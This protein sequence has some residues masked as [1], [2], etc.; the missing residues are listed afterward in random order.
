MLY[1]IIFRNEIGSEEII[2]IIIAVVAILFIV[3]GILVWLFI[4]RKS[5]TGYACKYFTCIFCIIVIF[6]LPIG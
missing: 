1:F 2:G 4:F 6:N 5:K 3:S